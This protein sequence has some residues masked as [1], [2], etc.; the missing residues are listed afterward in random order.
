MR[1]SPAIRPIASP[2]ATDRRG[3]TLVE[4]MI[5]L[6]VLAAVMVVLMTVMY[7]AQRSKTSTS[8]RV[9]SAQGARVAIDM[10]TRDL[11]S[12]GYGADLDW[13][14]SPQPPIAYIDSLQVLINANMSP[15]PDSLPDRPMGVPH[16][17][18]PA[19]WPR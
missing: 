11:R 3:F 16:A 6:T 8:N 15:W 2:R 18:D 9:E 1:T 13:L 5:T 14:A 19:G 7:A 10:M 12:A 4:L 17:Y